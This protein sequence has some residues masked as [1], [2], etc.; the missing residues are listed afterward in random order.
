MSAAVVACLS[1][2]GFG[3]SLIVAI[4]AQNAFVL[5]QGL[6][7]EHVLPI[8]AICAV[9]DALLI[10]VGV[11]GL[12]S[13]LQA[14][15]WMLTVV[16]VAGAAFLIAYGVL[17]ARRALLALGAG[18]RARGSAHR[19]VGRRDGVHRADLAEPAR[20]PGHGGS[21]RLGVGHARPGSLVVRAR[22]RRRQCAVVH[23]ARLR[24]PVPAPGVRP[25]R[26][27]ADPRRGD[28]RGDDRDRRRAASGSGTV[29]SGPQRGRGY[30]RAAANAAAIPARYGVGA[31][32]N[33]D[34][35]CAESKM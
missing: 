26:L 4:G 19:S 1:G 16:R 8:V 14:V 10:T 3:L 33:V 17:A 22:R 28:R 24:R 2:L 9:S 12:G 21:A 7:R 25:A 34:S 32:P 18:R 15:P 11:A 31:I 23:R 30:R 35:N 20:L 6:R 5:R 29:R 27:L 13:L